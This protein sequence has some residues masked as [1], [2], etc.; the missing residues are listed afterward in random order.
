M[1]IRLLTGIILLLLAGCGDQSTPS[2]DSGPPPDAE[3]TG[4]ETPVE[5]PAEGSPPDVAM[6]L[7]SLED[8]EKLI[9][10]HNGKVVVLDLW[11]LW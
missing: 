5:A 10:S 11:A 8:I 9:A 4:I 1:P 7:K 3:A 6:D 2:T